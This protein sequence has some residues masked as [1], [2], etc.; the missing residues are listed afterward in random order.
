MNTLNLFNFFGFGISFII[1]AEQEQ[2]KSKITPSKRPSS[3]PSQRSAVIVST[4]KDSL[5]KTAT[6]GLRKSVVSGDLM[7]YSYDVFVFYLCNLHEYTIEY[8]YYLQYTCSR[9]KYRIMSILTIVIGYENQPITASL[10]TRQPSTQS[11]NKL[12]LATADMLPPSPPNRKNMLKSK[13]K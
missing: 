5:P 10:N 11:T 4:G 13:I 2:I 12:S 3:D 9:Y 6:V 7:I 1:W 8:I